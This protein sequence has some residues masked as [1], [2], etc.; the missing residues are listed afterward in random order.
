MR[1]SHPRKGGWKTLMFSAIGS[2]MSAGAR[3][4]MLQRATIQIADA[5]ALDRWFICAWGIPVMVLCDF[6]ASKSTGSSKTGKTYGNALVLWLNYLFM[7][8]KTYE[9]ATYG[10]ARAFIHSVGMGISLDPKILHLI[11]IITLDTIKL[12]ISVIRGMYKYIDNIRISDDTPISRKQQIAGRKKAKHSYLYGNIWQKDVDSYLADIDILALPKKKEIYSHFDQETINAIMSNLRSLRDKAV[13][14]LL[15]EGLRIDEVLSTDMDGYDNKNRIKPGASKGLQKEDIEFIQFTNPET[16]NYLNA[17]I[18]NER[19]RLE[20]DLNKVLQPLFV[21]FRKGTDIGKR[22]TYSNF[23]QIIKCAAK[24][25]GLDPKKVVTHSGRRT[26]TENL[27]IHQVFHPE[28]G[29]TDEFIKKKRLWKTN[30]IGRYRDRHSLVI[31]A[32]TAEKIRDRKSSEK[33]C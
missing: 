11:P 1:I 20:N 2:V 12:Y 9:K 5:Q 25:A 31:A 22:L 29:I 23:N 21:N 26:D 30:Q 14:A 4:F 6:L 32:N 10:D 24:Q 17:Y 18:Y 8:G 27:L 19:N 15:L 3:K 16:E 7:K 28:D 33:K 13:F